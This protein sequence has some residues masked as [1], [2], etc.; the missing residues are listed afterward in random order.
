M[1]GA[2]EN[3]TYTKYMLTFWGFNICYSTN[4]YDYSSLVSYVVIL[5]IHVLFLLQD[6][7]KTYT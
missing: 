1:V 7:Y 2:G 4:L 6:L 5:N 3:Y